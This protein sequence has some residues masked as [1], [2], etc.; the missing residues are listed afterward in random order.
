MQMPEVNLD[1]F[2]DEFLSH[3][4]EYYERHN[5]KLWVLDVTNDLGIP[6]F[7]AISNRT[8][9]ESEDIIYAA[10][11][12][13]DPHIAAMRAICELNQFFNLVEPLGQVRKVY[14]INDPMTLQWF[15]EAKVATQSYL[16][17]SSEL[18]SRSRS[19]FQVPDTVDVLEDLEHYRSIVESKGMEFLV[20]DNTRPD[21]GMPV[22][23][24]IVPGLRH[25]WERFAPGRLFDVPV[26]MGWRDYP[27]KESQLN[28]N[29]VIA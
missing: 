24:V 20:L 27:L 13:T 25:F 23:R 26:E 3:A 10:G 21:I 19:D 4:N 1:S 17:P 28:P 6:V 16:A 2:D 9:K 22:V 12:H 18:P 5:R 29:P 15:N 11:A 7:V 8:D 14:Q